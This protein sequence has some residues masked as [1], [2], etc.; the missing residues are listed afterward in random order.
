MSP[1][2]VLVIGAGKSTYFLLEYLYEYVESVNGE[3]YLADAN[4]E[5]LQKKSKGKNIKTV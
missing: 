1:L 3:I 5:L 2:E 4:S